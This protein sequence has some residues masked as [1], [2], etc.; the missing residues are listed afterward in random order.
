MNAPVLALVVAQVTA[1]IAAAPAADGPDPIA[2]E[3]ARAQAIRGAVRAVEPAVVTIETIGGAQPLVESGGPGPRGRGPRRPRGPSG[4]VHERFRI[5]DGPTTGLVMS[6]DGL[7]ITSSINFARKP[8]V[9]TVTLAD[10]SR[11]VAELL[12]VDYIRRLAVIRIPAKDLPACDWVSA[13]ELRVGQYVIACGRGFGGTGVAPSLG[14][15]S[16]LNRRNGNAIQTDA[17]TSPANY[18][19]PLVDIEGRVAGLIVPMA[20]AGGALAG[21]QWYDG[22]IG[23]AIPRHKIDF[24]FDR[25]VAGET[26]EPGK[27][28]VVLA[29]ESSFKIPYFDDLFQLS[30]GVKI[31]AVAAKSPA[32]RAKLKAD[33]RLI[34]IDGQP[35]GDLLEVQRRLSDRA[36]GETITLTIDRTKWLV[37]KSFDVE[38]T[39]ARAADISGYGD[40]PEVSTESDAPTD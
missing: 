13:D 34:A 36:A 32:S 10:D 20:G 40:R 29:A 15:I 16:A 30:R 1:L 27:I 18:G 35:V 19:G 33:D 21:A 17:K 4:P 39:L 25:L 5:A 26:I 3:Q 38:I 31:N 23:F 24:V 9:I 37:R 28:G 2:F 8:T 22:G 14:I 6:P 7:I 11:H 12:G